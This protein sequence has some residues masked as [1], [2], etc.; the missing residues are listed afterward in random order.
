MG[1][2][3]LASIVQNLKGR[4]LII[5]QNAIADTSGGNIPNVE[6]RDWNFPGAC[7]FFTLPVTHP[8]QSP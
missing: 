3:L 5:S 6:V 1:I 7:V 2:S 8:D 4:L